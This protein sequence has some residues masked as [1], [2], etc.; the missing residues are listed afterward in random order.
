M[1]VEE[2]WRKFWLLVVT[3]QRADVRLTFDGE[4]HSIIDSKLYLKCSDGRTI[5]ALD[6]QIVRN[7]DGTTNCCLC[8]EILVISSTSK[9]D[10]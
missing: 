4:L 9:I 5:F 7:G 10:F 2:K 8:S 3:Q 1:W 6:Y